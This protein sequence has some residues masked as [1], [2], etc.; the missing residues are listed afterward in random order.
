MILPWKQR[1]I[2][3]SVDFESERS[4][5]TW[6]QSLNQLCDLGHEPLFICKM[7]IVSHACE[8]GV[9]NLF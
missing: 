5:L 4:T 9:L 6:A 1:Q 2:V 7:G 3:K 8:A